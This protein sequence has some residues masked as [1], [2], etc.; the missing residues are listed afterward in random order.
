MQSVRLWQNEEV[1]FFEQELLNGIFT[2]IFIFH[3]YSLQVSMF[4]GI[5]FVAKMST[6][7]VRYASVVSTNTSQ[8]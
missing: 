4:E 7:I 5:K 2:E 6:T 3:L 1:R 8:F